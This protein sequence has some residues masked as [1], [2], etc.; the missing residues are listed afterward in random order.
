MMNG[1]ALS[2]AYLPLFVAIGLAVGA[3]YFI[4]LRRHARHFF[5][6]GSPWRGVAY[7]LAR[8][9]LAAVAFLIIG[10]AGIFALVGS[11]AGFLVARTVVLKTSRSYD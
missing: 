9:T 7:A 4:A 1:H 8:V 10:Q 5:E 2:P 3:A 6:G 11:L